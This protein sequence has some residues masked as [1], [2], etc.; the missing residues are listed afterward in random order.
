[1]RVLTE[2]LQGNPPRDPEHKAEEH[3]D[4]GS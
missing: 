3:E 1:V 2:L 4:S